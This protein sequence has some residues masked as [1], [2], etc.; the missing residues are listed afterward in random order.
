MDATLNTSL[1]NTLGIRSRTVS[2]NITT[3]YT[4]TRRGAETQGTNAVVVGTTSNALLSIAERKFR[5]ISTIG[6]VIT[7]INAHARDIA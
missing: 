6:I 1:G 5:I 4:S 7:T 3:S 2:I